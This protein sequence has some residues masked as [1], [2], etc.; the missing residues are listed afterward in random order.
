MSARCT[1]IV[2]ADGMSSPLSMML[3]DSNRSKARSSKAVITSSSS[4]GAMRPCATAYLIS[5]AVALAHD[6]FPDRHRIVRH[7]KGAHRKTVDRRRRN[8]AHLAHPRQRQLQGAR[9]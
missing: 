9:D 4:E 8:E 2:L 6:R 7:H 1:T 5:G 3:V